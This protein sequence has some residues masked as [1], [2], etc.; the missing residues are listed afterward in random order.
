VT[1]YTEYPFLGIS[2]FTGTPGN[3]TQTAI[4]P[5]GN[6]FGGNN[7]QCETPQGTDLVAFS[8]PFVMDLSNPQRL[9]AGTNKVYETTNA[10]SATPTWTRL[11]TQTLSPSRGLSF[12]ALPPSGGNTI[13]TTS[14][15]GKVFR[16]TNADKGASTT[17]TDVTGNLP[18]PSSSTSN[19]GFKP[20]LTSVAFNPANSAEALVSV[21]ALGVGGVYHTTNAD[22]GAN[23]TWTNVSEGTKGGTSLPEFPVLSVVKEPT[24]GTI[25]VGTYYG[26]WQ[27]TSCAGTFNF[28]SWK[29][30]GTKLPINV[31][32]NKLTVSKDNKSLIAWTY[33]RGI[34]SL[35]L[36]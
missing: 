21:G 12:I 20:F 32:V 34:W 22:K 11:G 25:D 17:W 30:L 16:T 4:S 36:S 23:T 5:C 26:V 1:L 35:P 8:A 2:R 27:C 3:L 6:G 18:Q 13:F 7:N 31:E 14:I 29:R 9:L 24:T 15:D 10:K 19:P 33:G 28:P